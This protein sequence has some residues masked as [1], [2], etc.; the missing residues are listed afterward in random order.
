MDFIN[1][2]VPLGR[3]TDEGAPV[4]GNAESTIHSGFEMSLSA[5]PARFMDISGSFSYSSNYFVKYIQYDYQGNQI[6]LS[7]NTI[8]TFPEILAYLR[9][10]AHYSG[11]DSYIDAQ[12]VGK[13]FLDNTENDNRAIDPY[14]TMN[15]SLRYSY[16]DF[17]FFPEIQIFLKIYNLLN[18]EYETWGYYDEWS[19][20][21]YLY[22]AA[23]RYYYLGVN[24][25]L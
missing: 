7:G 24:L 2:I 17:Y 3:V 6:D 4:K 13:Q 12:Y 10:S 21:A 16:K 9:L 11:F 22:P 15:Y 25:N 14:L 18:A 1:E 8:A 20:E 19:A 23:T 5:Q